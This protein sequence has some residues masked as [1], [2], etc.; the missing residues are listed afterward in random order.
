MV[1]LIGYLIADLRGPKGG[2][3]GA[4]SP[5]LARCG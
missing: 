4:C 2:L 3:D 1:V 5:A